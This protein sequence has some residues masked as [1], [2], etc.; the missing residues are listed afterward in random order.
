MTASEFLSYVWSTLPL[1]IPLTSLNIPF[2]SSQ[3]STHLVLS[4]SSN[5]LTSILP[6][7]FYLTWSLMQLTPSQPL[8]P[9]LRLI[10]YSGKPPKTLSIQCFTA[11]I[12]MLLL[13]VPL[14]IQLAVLFLFL[15]AFILFVSGPLTINSLWSRN[16]SISFTYIGYVYFTILPC[17]WIPNITNI[18]IFSQ[19]HGLY[20]LNVQ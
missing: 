3:S 15:Y 18:W 13:T 8:C 2:C 5:T 4:R 17:V 6:Q 9:D 20:I 10:T 16:M 11:L 7:S 19:P 1:N 14:I 12:F